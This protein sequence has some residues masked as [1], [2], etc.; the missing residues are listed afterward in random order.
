MVA[1]QQAQAE[2]DKVRAANITG[3]RGTGDDGEGPPE[4]RLRRWL[5][6]IREV[7]LELKK[8][9]WPRRAEVVTYTLVVITTV[10]I[11]TALVFVLDFAFANTILEVFS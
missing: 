4:G 6:F 8:V 7:R 3:K 1:K 9:S 5:R 10:L 2:R 11:V